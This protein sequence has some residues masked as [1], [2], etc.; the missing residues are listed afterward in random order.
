MAQHLPILAVATTEVD[1]VGI[2]VRGEEEEE[3]AVEP[4]PPH[5][6]PLVHPLVGT[7]VI[8]TMP[9][10]IVLAVMLVV[11]NNKLLHYRYRP[12]RFLGINHRRR[13]V[14]LP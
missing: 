3:E 8:I 12:R 13:L 6:R 5:R 7:G 2:A 14:A 4:V 1:A 10:V 11:G 9:V